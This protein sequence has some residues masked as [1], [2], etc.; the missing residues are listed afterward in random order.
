MFMLIV[1]L[2]Y[3]GKLISLAP[4]VIALLIILSVFKLLI[5]HE[6]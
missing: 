6:T 1:A 3:V 2:A 4:Y 5:R